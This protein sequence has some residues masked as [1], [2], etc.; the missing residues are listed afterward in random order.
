M[1][2]SRSIVPSMYSLICEAELVTVKLSTLNPH[3]EATASV[4]T[5]LYYWVTYVHTEDLVAHIVL[6]NEIS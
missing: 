6:A 1:K 3:F 4:S 2:P 5:R